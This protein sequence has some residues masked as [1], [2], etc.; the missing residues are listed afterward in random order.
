MQRAPHTTSGLLASVLTVATL[1]TGCVHNPS[2]PDSLIRQALNPETSA[3]VLRSL[4]GVPHEEVRTAVALNANVPAGLLAEL[5]H[6]RDYGVVLTVAK[7]PNTPAETIIELAQRGH[8][9]LRAEVARNTG[10]P[11]FLLA[12]LANDRDYYTRATLAMN[13]S[14]PSATLAKLASSDIDVTLQI[15]GNPNTPSRTLYELAGEGDRLVLAAIC[16]NPRTPPEAHDMA[17]CADQ[18]PQTQSASVPVGQLWG[19]WRYT[20]I[21]SM[22]AEDATAAWRSLRV[23]GQEYAL[24]AGLTHGS[25]GVECLMSYHPVKPVPESAELVF[26][27]DEDV[28]LRRVEVFASMSEARADCRG[29]VE[30]RAGLDPVPVHQ[31]RMR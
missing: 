29:A 31:P 12:E 3:A 16:G 28:P 30:R 4:A 23:V 19:P 6:D 5:A 9:D 18:D 15:A 24:G 14:T 10:A 26:I 22:P 27:V 17:R 8:A 21:G 11:G 13:P 20:T 25:R 1:A 7:H 2:P